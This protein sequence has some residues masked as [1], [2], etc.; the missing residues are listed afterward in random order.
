MGS[1]GFLLIWRHATARS[2]AY[3]TSDALYAIQIV[4]RDEN[5]L[6]FAWRELET[7]ETP[8]HPSRRNR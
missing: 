6:T 1:G 3:G 7:Y 4:A 5:G 8:V 2:V